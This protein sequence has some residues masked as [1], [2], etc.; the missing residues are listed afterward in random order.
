L[1]TATPIAPSTVLV[2]QHVPFAASHTA[3]GSR[4][5]E[6]F[7]AWLT[8][9]YAAID[10]LDA[11]RFASFFAETGSFK[12]GNGAPAV[13]RDGVEQYTNGFYTV[14]AGIRHEL[15][16]AWPADEGRT[17]L[18]EGVVTYTRKDASKVSVPFFTVS[19]LDTA[20]L[21]VSYRVYADIA[22]LFANG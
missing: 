8:A 1:S 2:A 20:G 16:A 14:I 13:G 22:P 5:S 17:W 4:K 11:K 7:P 18:A 10:A 15:V 6:A 9:M 21:L 19:E 12:F 3:L